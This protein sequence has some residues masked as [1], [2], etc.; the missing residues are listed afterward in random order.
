MLPGTGSGE[1]RIAGWPHGKDV[2][3][4]FCHVVNPQVLTSYLR[5]GCDYLNS[6]TCCLLPHALGLTNSTHLLTEAR[7]PAA[8]QRAELI[9]SI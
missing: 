1:R 8:K 7:Y 5:M 3:V 4:P 2:K 6:R 9:W